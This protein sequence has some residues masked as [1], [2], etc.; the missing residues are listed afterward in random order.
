MTAV[1]GGVTKD[2]GGAVAEEN[3]VLVW[4]WA[5]GGTALAAAATVTPHNAGGLGLAVCLVQVSEKGHRMVT[6]SRERL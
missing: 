1:L 4:V 3:W 5:M 6:L 2:M